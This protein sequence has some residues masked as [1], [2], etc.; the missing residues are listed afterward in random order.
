VHK[1]T[2]WQNDRV[3]EWSLS[4]SEGLLQV[5]R[6]THSCVTWLFVDMWHDAYVRDMP[7]PYA[8]VGEIVP[9]SRIHCNTLQQN[10]NT[11]QHMAG[12]YQDCIS[13]ATHCNTLRRTATHFNLR[14]Y[15][16]KKGH[17]LPTPLH[18]NTTATH[19]NTLQN[20]A[21]HCNTLQH[22]ATHCNTLQ[23]TAT[24]CNTLQLHAV[25]YQKWTSTASATALQHNCNTLQH[26]ATHCNTLQHTAT[27]CN[28]LQH[29]ATHC[30]TR[31][32]RTKIGHLLPTPLLP[33]PFVFVPRLP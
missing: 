29:T 5:Y 31:R 16:F 1:M 9:R 12:S 20:T 8:H 19:Y 30:N 26:T 25:S 7:Y 2:K 15:R 14:Q 24:H 23:H 6:M 33:S 10:C 21:T 17:L 3:D 32:N 4:F 28:T 18:C 22:T 11:L 27:H 13:T